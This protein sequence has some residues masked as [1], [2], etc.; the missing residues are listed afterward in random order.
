MKKANRIQQ[1]N[2]SINRLD[3]KAPKRRI[4]TNPNSFTSDRRRENTIAKN[5]NVDS[6]KGNRGWTPNQLKWFDEENPVKAKIKATRDNNKL[7][8]QPYVTTSKTDSGHEDYHGRFPGSYKELERKTKFRQANK[9]QTSESRYMNHLNRMLI[10]GRTEDISEANPISGIKR[11]MKVKSDQKRWRDPRLSRN[12]HTDDK[13]YVDVEWDKDP[14]PQTKARHDMDKDRKWN[15]SRLNPDN[16]KRL[17]ITKEEASSKRIRPLKRNHVDTSKT[18]AQHK[19][20]K[21]KSRYDEKN[22]KDL[23]MADWIKAVR[24]GD[25]DATLRKKQSNESQYPDWSDGAHQSL[26]EKAPHRKH[27]GV[28]GGTKDY[29]SWRDN[30]QHKTAD[31]HFS[32]TSGYSTKPIKGL[33]NGGEYSYTDDNGKLKPNIVRNKKH[34]AMRSIEQNKKIKP[35]LPKDIK[36]EGIGSAIKNFKQK[37]AAKGEVNSLLKGHKQGLKNIKWAQ[38]KGYMDPQVS[39]NSH[40]YEKAHAASSVRDAKRFINGQ[41]PKY[42]KPVTGRHPKFQYDEA[43]ASKRPMPKRYEKKQGDGYETER[44]SHKSPAM[45]RKWDGQSEIE[46]ERAVIKKPSKSNYR[47]NNYTSWDDRKKR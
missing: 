4:T 43:L 24:N 12:P 15:K 42:T 7:R 20:N 29:D 18:L 5:H 31:D 35:K 34:A 27:Y 36:Q 25:R 1:M 22:N 44:L 17:G 32:N 10:E 21:L 40:T 16:H 28:R 13:A 45:R 41:K 11:K 46:R 47:M 39:P 19:A 8:P 30:T 33:K 3:E 6:L 38:N 23:D 9:R 26:D 37:R 14:K 2:E